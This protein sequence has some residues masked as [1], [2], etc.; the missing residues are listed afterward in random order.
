MHS[1]ASQPRRTVTSGEISD[2]DVNLSEAIKKS[3][4]M[5]DREIFLAVIP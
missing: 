3:S 5:D 4:E 2:R 1:S